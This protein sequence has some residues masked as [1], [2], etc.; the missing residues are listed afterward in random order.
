[1]LVV[2]VALAVVLKA[3]GVPNRRTRDV[4]ASGYVDAT[5]VVHERSALARIHLN[6]AWQ[7]TLATV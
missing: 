7:P 2:L 1:M 4:E 5:V 3:P 6:A